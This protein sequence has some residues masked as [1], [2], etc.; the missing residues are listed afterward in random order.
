MF[1]KYPCYKNS[2]GDVTIGLSVA[3]FKWTMMADN[4]IVAWAPQ[5][6][7]FRYPPSW[8]W[9]I[10]MLFQDDEVMGGRLPPCNHRGVAVRASS[11]EWRPCPPSSAG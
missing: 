9:R 3:E 1:E 10:P 7:L 8:G 6:E 11:D 5:D 2:T 4:E